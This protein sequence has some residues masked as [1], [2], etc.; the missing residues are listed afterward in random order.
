MT[1]R[2]LQI[3]S[4]SSSA[5]LEERKLVARMLEKLKA[6][7]DTREAKIA[8]V[9]NAIFADDY[10]NALKLD[11]AAERVVDSL[12]SS[13]RPGLLFLASEVTSEAPPEDGY[14]GTD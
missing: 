3:V 11:V 8:R 7:K 4:L 14:A 6:G 1:H 9:R 10:E 12:S 5:T 13:R 2:K